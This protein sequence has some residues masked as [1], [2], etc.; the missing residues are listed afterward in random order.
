MRGIPQAAKWS[1]GVIYHGAGGDRRS[2]PSL[3]WMMETRN[4]AYKKKKKY[5]ASAREESAP[6]CPVSKRGTYS[7]GGG[8]RE[9]R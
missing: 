1:P 8:L 3:G 7:G 6:R 2:K 9:G 5:T 4:S